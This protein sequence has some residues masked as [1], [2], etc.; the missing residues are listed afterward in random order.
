MIES[1]QLKTDAFAEIYKPY[2]RDV[3]SQVIK[4]HEE[5]GGMSRFHK[6]KIYHERYLNIPL[7]KNELNKLLYSKDKVTH[8]DKI[9]QEAFK[10]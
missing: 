4:H 7:S 10:K 9:F 1:V 8:I 6:F 5:N 2:G 3:V